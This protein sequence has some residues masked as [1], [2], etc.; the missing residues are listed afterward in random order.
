[1]ARPKTR[2]AKVVA[3]VKAARGEDRKAH[4]AEGKTAR[5]WRPCPTMTRNQRREQS[6][7]ACRERVRD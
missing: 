5:M 4:F 3:A 2:K 1:M 7:K 6:R